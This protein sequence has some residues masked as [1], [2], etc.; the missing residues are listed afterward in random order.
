MKR[1]ADTSVADIDPHS[2]DGAEVAA[3]VF[4]APAEIGAVL[5]AGV[6]GCQSGT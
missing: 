5:A 6:V 2:G 3:L 4:A 1:Q